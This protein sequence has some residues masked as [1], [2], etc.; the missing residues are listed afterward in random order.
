MDVY[1]LIENDQ[2]LDKLMTEYDK[3]LKRAEKEGKSVEEIIDAEHEELLQEIRDETKK[4]KSRV[5]KV[6]AFAVMLPQDDENPYRILCKKD[7]YYLFPI[8]SGN[9]IFDFIRVSPKPSPDSY[10]EVDSPI[11]I[12]I[13]D[14]KLYAQYDAGKAFIGTEKELDEYQKKI[15]ENRHD[16]S[17]NPTIHAAIQGYFEETNSNNIKINRITSDNSSIEDEARKYLKI[18]GIRKMEKAQR[19]ESRTPIPRQRPPLPA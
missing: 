13:G 5:G 16:E 2:A 9:H 6:S 1:D 4:I 10:A 11:E 18:Q 19:I 3:T 8:T 17:K 12:E 7:D 14:E 15:T